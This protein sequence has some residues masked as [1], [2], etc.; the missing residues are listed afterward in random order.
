MRGESQSKYISGGYRS[1]TTGRTEI[2]ER[3]R[4]KATAKNR[5]PQVFA[6]NLRK[7]HLIYRDA[8]N[9]FSPSGIHD[10]PELMM[11]RSFANQINDTD[12]AQLGA[13]H[14]RAKRQPTK[15]DRDYAGVMADFIRQ[16]GAGDGL[17]AA[18]YGRGKFTGAKSHAAVSNDSTVC[19]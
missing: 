13:N 19:R 10:L 5:S 6:E 1:G 14:T 9:T 16:H 17:A 11:V 2:C 7:S 8:M 15:D 12:G 4:I 3:Q 18:E